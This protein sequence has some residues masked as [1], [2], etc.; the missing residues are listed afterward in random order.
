MNKPRWEIEKEKNFEFLR[1]LYSS[2]ISG[3]IIKADQTDHDDGL[4]DYEDMTGVGLLEENTLIMNDTYNNAYVV[5]Q[6]EEDEI[7]IPKDITKDLHVI[8]KYKYNKDWSIF[9]CREPAKVPNHLQGHITIVNYNTIITNIINININ[10]SA[11]ESEISSKPVAKLSL[12]KGGLKVVEKQT[13]QTPSERNP[14]RAVGEGSGSGEP[15]NPSQKRGFVEGSGVGFFEK[16]YKSGGM[17]P[18]REMKA[19]PEWKDEYANRIETKKIHICKSCK[20]KWMKGCC[21]DYSR[22]N[23][24]M[25]KMVIGWHE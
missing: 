23:R 2:Q 15:L 18:F 10:S 5:F 7:V 19:H 11:P 25:W 14:R 4:F 17:C 22:E 24:V 9:R 21:K 8:N 3:I 12:P 16:N 6:I 20:Q 1:S 13:Q